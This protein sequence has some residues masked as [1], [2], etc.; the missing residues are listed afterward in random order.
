MVNHVSASVL[1]V[2]IVL[3]LDS[4]LGSLV[5]VISHDH[6]GQINI[7]PLGKPLTHPFVSVK[8]SR[9]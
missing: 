7:Q 8:P 1:A 9:G 6:C 3:S 2:V 5:A 4:T